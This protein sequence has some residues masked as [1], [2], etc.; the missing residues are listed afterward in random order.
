VALE[1]RGNSVQILHLADTVHDIQ[2]AP[3]T[4]LLPS[5]SPQWFAMNARSFSLARDS[6]L[7]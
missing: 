1:D 2:L 7:R 3:A 5:T 4:R 6:R